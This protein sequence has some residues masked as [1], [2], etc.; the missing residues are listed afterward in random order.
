MRAILSIREISI[1]PERQMAKNPPAIARCS[2]YPLYPAFRTS[3]Y[4]YR[5]ASYKSRAPPQRHS[6]HGT[7]TIDD[8]Q[9]HFR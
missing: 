5:T 4:D 9:V 6:N 1:S 8:L 3:R 7:R 2:G